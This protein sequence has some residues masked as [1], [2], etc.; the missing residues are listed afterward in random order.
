MPSKSFP[1]ARE[2]G[3][4]PG[5]WHPG[6]LTVKIHSPKRISGK[7][8]ALS[9]TAVRRADGGRAGLCGAVAVRGKADAAGPVEAVWHGVPRETADELVG[10]P[11]HGLCVAVLSQSFRVKP[12]LP[13]S[14]PARAIG[15]CDAVSVAAGEIDE[16]AR[17]PEKALAQTLAPSVVHP[18]APSRAAFGRGT[19]PPGDATAGQGRPRRIMS[20]GP[21]E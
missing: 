6:S 12:T 19:R 20:P 17:A 18:P 13:S 16:P 2:Y 9:V 5:R 1:D 11:H 4:A 10:F 3:L 14:G 21:S 15:D 8:L 7:L